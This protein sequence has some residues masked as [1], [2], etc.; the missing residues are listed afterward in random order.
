M[1]NKQLKEVL[2]FIERQIQTPTIEKKEL[3]KIL[4]LAYQKFRIKY[5][6]EIA[7]SEEIVP[8]VSDILKRK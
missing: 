1:V 3:A 8:T 5:V 2:E 7:I 4:E 6:S